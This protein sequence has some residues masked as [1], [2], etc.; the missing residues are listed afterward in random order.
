MHLPK[1]AS[2]VNDCPVD[3]GAGQHGKEGHEHGLEAK[4]ERL[5]SHF[6]A[7]Q[8]NQNIANPE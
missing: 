6:N 1:K 7:S 4:G 5:V 2:V 8:G 3:D